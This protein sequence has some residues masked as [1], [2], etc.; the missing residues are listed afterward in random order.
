MTRTRDLPTTLSR[1]L[2]VALPFVLATTSAR[3][4]AAGDGASPKPW[5]KTVID[6]AHALA[7]QKVD[8]GTDGEVRWRAEAKALIDDTLDW[9]ELTEQALGKQWANLPEAERAEFTRL[10]REMIEASYQS[11]LGLV[12]T[13]GVKKPEQVKIDWLD[14]KLEDGKATVTA[15]VKTEKNVA[16]IEFKLRSG[17]G[18]WRVFDVAIDDVSTIR[19]YRT[20]FGKIIAKDGFPALLE[21]MRGKIQEI[22]A[23]RADLGP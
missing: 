2:L 16:V 6:K 21:R 19:T 7:R 22:R 3:A 18:R 12:A 23:G 20:Q 4:N 17:G 15:R 10:F 5:L 1:T 13:G 9:A 14:E 11:K 8:A